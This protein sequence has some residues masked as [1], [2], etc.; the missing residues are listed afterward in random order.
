M[1]IDK[2]RHKYANKGTLDESLSIFSFLSYDLLR[3]TRNEDIDGAEGL[4]LPITSRRPE[5]GRPVREVSLKRISAVIS[6]PS[7]ISSA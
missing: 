2:P 7:S 3:I 1:H 4:F 5:Q 6:V